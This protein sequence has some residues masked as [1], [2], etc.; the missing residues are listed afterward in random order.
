MA[1]A[2]RAPPPSDLRSGQPNPNPSSSLS[3]VKLIKDQA[4]F[5]YQQQQ[6][7]AEHTDTKVRQLL[8]LS[9]SFAT[10]A[11]ALKA[12]LSRLLFLMVFPP[13][14]ACI[15][16]CIELLSVRVGA[17]PNLSDAADHLE[18]IWVHD[19]V[20]ATNFNK[21]VHD[22][23]VQLYRAAINWFLI[24]FLLA[25]GAVAL[26]GSGRLSVWAYARRQPPNAAN[27]TPSP[28]PSPTPA[29]RNRGPARR[30]GQAL[31]QPTLAVG[32]PGTRGD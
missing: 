1:R 32:V 4:Q 10:V 29:R 25:V 5:R 27:N 21:S 6:E 22:Y 17:V 9:S 24:A 20:T 8:T 14:A 15:Y 28:L 23:H 18:Q 13:L 26:Y 30:C 2:L 7:A 19:L 12:Y 3:F 11:I 16:I 31:C